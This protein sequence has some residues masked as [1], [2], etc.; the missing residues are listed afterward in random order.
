MSDP[1]AVP[2]KLPDFVSANDVDTEPG[3]GLISLKQENARLRKER[4]DAREQLMAQSDPGSVPPGASSK[5]KTLKA[6][7]AG[8]KYAVLVP[9]IAF[10]A[11]AAARKW[12]QITEVVDGVLQVLGL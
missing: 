12:P 7:L 1:P 11:R 4:N 10:A 6:A 3:V 5:Q 2:P 8:T 9:V